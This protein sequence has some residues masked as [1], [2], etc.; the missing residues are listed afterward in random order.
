MVKT[1][2]KT[3]TVV[4]VAL[5]VIS[6]GSMAA[7]LYYYGV[8]TM[9]DYSFSNS[10]K[11][12]QKSTP[13]TSS[14]YE[15][16]ANTVKESNTFTGVLSMGN[17]GI[18]SANADGTIN[19]S[20][21]GRLSIKAATN[22]VLK[23][24]NEF[25][26]LEVIVT[27]SKK[28]FIPGAEGGNFWAAQDKTFYI[29][30][31]V[32]LS[33][34]PRYNDDSRTVKKAETFSGK[35]DMSYDKYAAGEADGNV[36]RKYVK[37]ATNQILADLKKYNGLEVTVTSSRQYTILASDPCN[38]NANWTCWDHIFYIIDSVKLSEASRVEDSPNIKSESNTFTGVLSMGN[39]GIYS[40]SAD[41]T[42][43]YKT[44]IKA[45][46]NAILLELNGFNGKEVTVTS[47]KKEFIQ[48]AEGGNFQAAQDRTFYIIDSVKLAN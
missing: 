5:T 15:D 7:G 20:S 45:A 8:R 44:L 43:N 28:E 21:K 40:G 18:Y 34:A 6:I 25:N 14:K 17:M 35:L 19:S 48:G 11:E 42:I 13:S 27:S 36:N 24:L 37:A 3:K 33:E 4:A 10:A 47:S 32:K 12:N 29:I 9:K 39:M 23:E 1:Q 26:G 46:T 31:S 16:N 2:T 38:P 22:A 30:D 41:G